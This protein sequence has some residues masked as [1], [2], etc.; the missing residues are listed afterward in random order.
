MRSIALSICVFLA[1]VS[2][3]AQETRYRL[4]RVVVENS[5]IDQ[6][7]IRAETRLEEEKSYT[8]ADFRQAVYRV[9]RLPFVTDAVYRIEPGVTG[10]GSTL[11]IR[12]L[13][14]TPVYYGINAGG[15]RV[16]DGDT[17]FT[18][19]GLLGGRWLLDNLGVIETAVQKTE[20]E[21]GWDV[22]L[23][24][25]AYD[26]YGTGGFASLAIAQR[27][28]TDPRLYDP[29]PVLNLGY[30]LTQRQT[31]TLSASRFKTR[32]PRDFDVLGDDDDNE[33]DDE[34]DEDDNVTLTDRDRVQFAELRWWYETHDDPIFTT[35]GVQL[36]F[37]PR[38]SMVQN[39][40][41]AYDS[42][43]EEVVATE[44]ETTAYGLALDAA[45]YRPF[46][47]RNSVFL[48]LGGV[49]SRID[50]TEDEFM[51]GSASVGLTH[52]F[53]TPSDSVLHNVRARFEVGA[54]YRSSI[55]RPAS[56]EETRDSSAFGE[57]AFVMRHRLGSI[58]L[59]LFYDAD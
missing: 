9:R 42:E 16:S 56:G 5:N 55:F 57:A 33:D 41:E 32:L 40:T 21:D 23:A 15:E 22:G 28:K 4:E 12:I 2:S 14:T 10:G 47:S 8:D 29:T 46:S 36:S 54:G 7:I 59:S 20:G 24:Y 38:W 13:D 3:F 37:G 25:R 49:A 53:H 34:T 52:D 48:R 31:I 58:R 11:V 39:V 17:E 6:D 19:S 26:I 1:A 45:G 44:I 30:P 27:F 35:R 18:G 43:E 51:N 50:D